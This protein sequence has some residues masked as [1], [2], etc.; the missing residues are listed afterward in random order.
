MRSGVYWT[1]QSGVGNEDYTTYTYLRSSSQNHILRTIKVV[2]D[3]S[4]GQ[5]LLDNPNCAA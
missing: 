2:H 4:D 3:S 5:Y 1:K